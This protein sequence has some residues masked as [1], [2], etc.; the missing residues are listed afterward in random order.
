MNNLV[1]SMFC[2][3]CF[4]DEYAG[5]WGHTVRGGHCTNCGNG[6]TISIPTWAINEI[7]RTASWVG[8]RYY[9][10]AEDHEISKER[11]ALLA[12]VK[13]F[14]GRTASEDP[15]NPGR[16]HVVQEAGRF[17]NYRTISTTVDAATADEAMRKC[18]LRYIPAEELKLPVA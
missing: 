18:G 17:N 12:L 16:W 5:S 3:A 7:R 1:M 4:A 10:D 11:E 14:P 9:P 13:Q 8:K 6:S 15:N 2:P